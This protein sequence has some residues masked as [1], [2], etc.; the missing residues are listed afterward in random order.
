[1][2]EI[3]GDIVQPSQ[4]ILPRISGATMNISGAIFLSGAKVWFSP[5]GTG[6]HELITSAA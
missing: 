5:G 3:I 1:M 6:A 4:L 2:T